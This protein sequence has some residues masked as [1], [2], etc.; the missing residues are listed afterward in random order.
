MPLVTG[1]VFSDNMNLLLGLS[2]TQT[3]KYFR[4]SS[5]VLFDAIQEYAREVGY[6][7]EVSDRPDLFTFTPI[8]ALRGQGKDHEPMNGICSV[9]RSGASVEPICPE[10]P[11]QPDDEIVLD[12]LFC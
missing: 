4:A 12:I 11:L 10:L 7:A 5:L 1:L 9:R 2:P 8:T 3:R 6:R